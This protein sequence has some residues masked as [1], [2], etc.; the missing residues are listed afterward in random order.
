MSKK[1]K[2]NRI[3]QQEFIKLCESMTNERLVNKEIKIAF[4]EDMLPDLLVD[5][6]IDNKEVPIISYDVYADKI[7]EV[8]ILF[9]NKIA[10]VH[11][12]S[13][14]ITQERDNGFYTSTWQEP[15]VK[16]KYNDLQLE[17]SLLD[18]IDNGA[19]IYIKEYDLQKDEDFSK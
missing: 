2:I 19:K 1:D 17:V 15:F 5:F 7:K 10:E 14:V 16:I 11:S 4:N 18:L 3:Y 6:I 13:N 8:T 12:V 9:P